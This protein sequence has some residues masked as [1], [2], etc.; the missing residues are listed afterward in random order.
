[1]ALVIAAR[2]TLWTVRA[3]ANA[4]R[5][6]TWEVLPSVPSSGGDYLVLHPDTVMY[7]GTHQ[8]KALYKDQ[9]LAWSV[10]PTTLAAQGGSGALSLEE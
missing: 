9:S 10:T 2:T 1:M 8:I 6:T 7:L 3:R 5:T 4:S